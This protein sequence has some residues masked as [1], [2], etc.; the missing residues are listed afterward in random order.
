MPVKLRIKGTDKVLH[1]NSGKYVWNAVGHAKAALRTSGLSWASFRDLQEQYPDDPVLKGRHGYYRNHYAFDQIAHM[2]EIVDL[3]E[4]D[5]AQTAKIV[6][7]L[8]KL[9]DALFHSDLERVYPDYLAESAQLRKE[10][11]NG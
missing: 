7:M 5:K 1:M 10:L 9:E 3:V 4:E 2:I 6:A 11:S 8:L